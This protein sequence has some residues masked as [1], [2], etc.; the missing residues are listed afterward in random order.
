MDNPLPVKTLNVK[1]YIKEYE[2][3]HPPRKGQVPTDPSS[4]WFKKDAMTECVDACR[5]ELYKTAKE[6]GLH[7]RYALLQP[8]CISACRERLDQIS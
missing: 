6:E 3:L 2:S 1:E 4:R 7:E 5:Y 8:D